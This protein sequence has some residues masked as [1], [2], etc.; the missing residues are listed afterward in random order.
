MES[1]ESVYVGMSADLLH[2]GHL[3]VLQAAAE[4]G[5]VTVGLLTDAAIASYKRVPFMSFEQR[6]RMI[7][8]VKG[9]TRVVPQETLDYEPNLRRYRPDIVVHGDDWVSGVQQHVRARVIEVLSEWGGRL[10]E[11]PYTQDISS[12]QIIGA[13]KEIGTTPG[14]R[15]KSLRRLLAAKPLVRL[16][17]VHS[18]ITGLIVENARVETR[19]GIREFDGMWASSLTSSTNKG[20]PDTELIDLTSRVNTLNEILDVTT[21]PVIYDG[22]TGGHPAH[23]RSTVKTLERHGISAVII[24]DKTGLKK[25]S[26]FGNEVEQVQEFDG[27][28]L[29]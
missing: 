23:F 17:E 13:L 8:S 26:L 12:T 25:N 2:V 24:E 7:D 4:L 22:D 21:K 27:I 29:G 10:V 20:K 6:M 28:I 9:V 5:S 11:V 15:L 3:N 14:V 18:A 16:L 19:E 1:S